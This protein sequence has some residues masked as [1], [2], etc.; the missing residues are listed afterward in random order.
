MNTYHYTYLITNLQPT[1]E[2]KY[3]IGVRSAKVIPEADTEY[4][5]SSAYLTEAI[6]HCGLANFEKIII[7]VW[8]NRL[9][10]NKHERQLHDEYEVA[11]NTLFYNKA[12]AR[13]AGFCGGSVAATRK[14]KITKADPVWQ[15]TVGQEQQS[16]RCRTMKTD[17]WQ[18]TKGK[19]KIKKQKETR[20]DPIWKEQIGKPAVIKMLETK[21]DPLWMATTGKESVHRANTTKQDPIWKEQIGKPAVIKMLETKSD[22]LWMAMNT[23]TC[24]HCHRDIKGLGVFN[25][26]HD[27]NCKYKNKKT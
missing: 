11:S 19:E 9:Y 26:W 1:T 21:S 14:H 16:N 18:N 12:K 23:Y 15:Q 10:A 6:Q 3:Y 8:D 4:M 5:G 20:A 25:R 24:V 27:D 7:K 17:A 22:P 2:E 13:P